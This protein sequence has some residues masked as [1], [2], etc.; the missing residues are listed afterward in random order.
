MKNND[1]ETP[2]LVGEI[3]DFNM[4]TGTLIERLVFNHRP[5]VLSVFILLTLFFAYE[6]SQL[7]INSSYEQMMPSKHQYIQNYRANAIDLR[8]LGNSVRIAVENT[9]GET[10]YDPHYLAM[11]KEI[12]DRVFLLPG[13]DRSYMKSLWMSS[14]MWTAVTEQGFEGGPV[15]PI[16]YDG[17]TESLNKLEMNIQKA[18]IIGDLVALDGKSSMIVVPL[19][20]KDSAGKELDYKAFTDQLNNIKE[21][22]SN[23][24]IT[25]HT[26]GFAKLMGDLILGIIKIFSYFLIAA[27]IVTLVLFWYSRCWR[28]SFILVC[29]SILG[30]VWQLGIM[31]LLGYV[32]DPFSVLVPFLA[33]AIGVSHGTQMMNGTLNNLANGLPR[34]L[35]ARYTFRTLY[36]PGLTALLSDA[37]GFAVLYTIPIPVIQNMA[38][39]ASIGIAALIFSNLVVIPIILSYTGCCKSAVERVSITANIHA[40]KHPIS[41]LLSRFIEPR[42]AKYVIVCT[43]LLTV[44]GLLI[45]RNMKIGDVGDGAPE[46]RADSVYNQDIKYFREHYGLSSDIFAVI[47]K[48]PQEG[49]TYFRS[50]IEMDRLEE[51]LRDLP[52]VQSTVSAS[53]LSRIFTSGSFEGDPRWFTI[54]RDQNLTGDATNNVFTNRPGMINES[55]TVAPIIVYLDNH[56]AE[57]LSKLVAVVQ[58]FMR[59]HNSK[60]ISFSM[61][62]GNAGIEAATNES[63]KW[64]NNKMT[65]IVYIV[66]IALCFWAFKSWRGV[67]SAILPLVVMTI[68]AQALMVMLNIGLKVATL[69]VI[70]LGVGIGVDYAL[71]LLT[72]FNNKRREGKSN[73][74]AYSEALVSTGKGI[75]LVGITLTIAVVTWIWSPI[76]F[77]ADLGKLLSFMFLGNMIGAL[78]ILPALVAFLMPDGKL[79]K[80]AA[81]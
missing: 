60:D 10:I 5:Y 52:F 51:I 24:G 79:N 21:Q 31:N 61:A 35:A 69:P 19:N 80:S 9:Q 37:V 68:L 58:K 29:C 17:S 2:N 55:R 12:N 6:V 71:Y 26:V 15:M 70:A 48:T 47:V 50:M 56:K 66:V 45:G 42:I 63:V 75:A 46:L 54:S 30:V 4:K 62:A 41:K 64:A 11:L 43:I 3:K 28:S 34:Y 44:V 39:Q 65:A 14:V 53:S 59:E 20:E 77:Q 78:V 16:D 23:K 13:V 72:I 76:K 40:S 67:L 7:R 18:G 27:L 81:S 33:F 25:V 32:L 38:V 1:N 36:L 49:L 57:T 22:Y 74:E 73:E 8:M